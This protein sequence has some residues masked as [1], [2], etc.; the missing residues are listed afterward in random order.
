M[1]QA[2][3]TFESYKRKVLK[4]GQNFNYDNLQMLTNDHFFMAEEEDESAE[5]DM[6]VKRLEVDKRGNVMKKQKAN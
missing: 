2:K 6:P 5:E 1:A 3:K 4:P